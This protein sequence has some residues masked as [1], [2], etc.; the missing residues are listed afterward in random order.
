[1]KRNPESGQALVFAA[2]AMFVLIGFAGLAIDMGALRYQKRLQQ[3][4]ADAAAIAGA[5][6][7]ASASLGVKA[8]AQNAAATNG[9]TD[10]SGGTTCTNNPGT[11]GCITVAVNNPPLSGPHASAADADKYVEVLVTVVQPTYFMKAVGIPSETIT[12]RAVATNVSGGGP[13]SGC[14]YTLG[15]PSSSIEGVNINGSATLNATTCGIDDNGDF[16]TKGNALT[17]NSATFGVSGDWD[18]KGP[19]GTVTCGP[20]Q[21]SC[22]ATNIPAATDPFSNQLT[23]PCNPCTGGGAWVAGDGPGTYSSINIGPATVNFSPGVY[24][25]DGSGGLSIG[26]NATVC[27]QTGS[28][29]SATGTP[30]AGVT[31]YFTNGAT[32]NMVG[33]P[34]VYLTAPGT[35]GQYP[36]ILFYQDPADT[37]GPTIGGNSGSFFDGVLY[38]P[39]ANVTFFGNA[40][41]VD[42][43][44]V[45]ADALT[46]SGNP[47]INLQGA[48]GLPT[49]VS[50]LTHAV[51]VE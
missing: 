9:F 20:T 13:N 47:T 12:A 25:I 46:L 48:A 32:L 35:S 43:A 11:L 23:P 17:V 38:F 44:M 4:A 30:N 16:N 40:S 34:V 28:G 50:F 26:A 51:L 15:P 27:N 18:K 5:S 36:G 41:S 42:A 3:T 29:C 14:L 21:P 6:N 24:I 37:T 49:G 22:P 1:M 2:L 8:G 7:L 31:F 45:V 33:T 10:N 39:T 19:G